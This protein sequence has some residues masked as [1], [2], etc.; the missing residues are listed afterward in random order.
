MKGIYSKKETESY[1]KGFLAG[2]FKGKKNRAKKTRRSYVKSKKN[3]KKE[4]LLE[5]SENYRKGNLGA[6]YFDG[7]I[8]DTNFEGNPVEIT[9]ADIQELR[10]EYDQKGQLSD[11]E[12]ANQ[13]VKHMRRKY[14]VFNRDGRFLHMISEEDM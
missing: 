2:F 8:Y 7:K 11:M 1:K 6:L 14:G 3:S 9:K 13:Y 10:K 5:F 4:K 12:V